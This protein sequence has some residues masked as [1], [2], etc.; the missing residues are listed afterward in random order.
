MLVL[1]IVMSEEKTNC[2]HLS[3]H[4]RK[5]EPWANPWT[6]ENWLY[7]R[8]VLIDTFKSP[9]SDRGRFKPAIGWRVWAG[10][11][12]AQL[13]LGQFGNYIPATAQKLYNLLG[14]QTFLHDKKWENHTFQVYLI[15]IWG[16]LFDVW[17]LLFYGES[18]KSFKLARNQFSEKLMG[19]LLTPNSK[20]LAKR[21]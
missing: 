12:E 18:V 7:L 21:P 11:I 10:D 15:E 3:N 13:S 9:L 1:L 2:E 4:C 6:T 16:A 17:S 20:K 8:I 5:I 14:C 19:T